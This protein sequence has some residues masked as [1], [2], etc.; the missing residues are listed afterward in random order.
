MQAIFTKNKSIPGTDL[1]VGASLGRGFFSFEE[2]FSADMDFISSASVVSEKQ[3]FHQQNP[4][5]SK[6]LT[7]G[8]L[9]IQ[10]SAEIIAD[11]SNG[12]KNKLL[13]TGTI[14]MI[15]SYRLDTGWLPTSGSW[16][17]VELDLKMIAIGQ[18]KTA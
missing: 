5:D 4:S 13:V 8:V 2:D 15:S 14:S 3:T 17:D 12:Q 7:P 6:G 10:M 9:S 11:T 18:P 1:Q 16:D